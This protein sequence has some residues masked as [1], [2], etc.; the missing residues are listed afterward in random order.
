MKI[1]TDGSYSLKTKK[2][3]WGFVSESGEESFGI[4]VNTTSNRMELQAV[5]E[6][7]KERELHSKIQIFTD[8]EYVKNGITQWI[9]RWKRSKW[10]T[11]SRKPVKNR[12]LWEK[13]DR[14]RNRLNVEWNWVK[15]HS[16]I[17]LNERADELAGKHKGVMNH[18]EAYKR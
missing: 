10:K 4:E 8:S 18:E 11:S 2:G 6:A 15:S 3:G 13:L 5:I 9:I 17:P 1:Y 7:L 14:A 12:D 16:G